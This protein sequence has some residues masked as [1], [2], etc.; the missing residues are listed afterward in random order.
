[1]TKFIRI[2]NFIILKLNP[3]GGHRYF[4]PVYGIDSG[5]LNYPANCATFQA[6]IT[7]YRFN[8]NKIY[9]KISESVTYFY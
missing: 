4:L 7:P 8:N 2:V 5:S 3:P 1:M 9:S 6:T